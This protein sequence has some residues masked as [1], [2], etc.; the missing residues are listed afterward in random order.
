MQRTLVL[1]AT[2]LLTGSLAWAEAPVVGATPTAADP[3]LTGGGCTLPDLAGLTR[4]QLAAAALQ[5]GFQMKAASAEDI[6][7]CPT[8]FHCNSLV[9]CD[10]APLCSLTDIGQCCSTSGAIICCT[11]G[12]IIV[13]RCRCECTGPVCSV[14]CPG[15]Q[16]VDRT[17]S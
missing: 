11:S 13:K 8:V 5:A 7:A 16:E 12:H 10:A 6:Q 15:S 1:I 3:R 9:G 17:C 4:E 14:L 2:L